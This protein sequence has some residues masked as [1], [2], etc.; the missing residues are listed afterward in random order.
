MSVARV[1]PIAGVTKLAI[2]IAIAAT[3]SERERAAG[4]TVAMARRLCP[5]TAR[6]QAGVETLVEEL[7]GTW[8]GAHLD[9]AAVGV[10]REAPERRDK[11]RPGLRSE[12]VL[13]DA[14][15]PGSLGN[16]SR[17]RWTTGSVRLGPGFPWGFGS[18]TIGSWIRDSMS[19]TGGRLR[20]PAEGP[21]PRRAHD[22]KRSEDAPHVA[23]TTFRPC[24]HH[25]RGP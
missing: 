4:A 7:A 17:Y 6:P 21:R 1:F 14:A 24:R 20:S 22:T 2:A 5:L 8:C 13:R 12:R 10:D 3:P 23:H 25:R 15:S 9:G 16:R 11:N 18:A 19:G